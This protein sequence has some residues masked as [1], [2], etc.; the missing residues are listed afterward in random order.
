MIRLEIQ[1]YGNID[2]ELDYEHAPISAKNF[3]DLV[4]KG[5]YDGLTFHRVIKGF[6]IQGGCPRGNGT[7]GPGYTIEGEF[8]ANGHDNPISHQRGVILWLVPKISIPQEANSSLCIK[9]ATS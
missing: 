7:G 4:K 3:E 1:D 9:M 6:M 5:F 8:K 2:I